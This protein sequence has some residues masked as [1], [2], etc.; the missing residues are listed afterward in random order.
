MLLPGGA[1]GK[2]QQIPVGGQIEPLCSSAVAGGQL[3]TEELGGEPNTLLRP[4]NG[5][6]SVPVGRQA[7][8]WPRYGP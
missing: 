2:D 7:Q 5:H 6:I 4:L 1:G 3:L 8:V